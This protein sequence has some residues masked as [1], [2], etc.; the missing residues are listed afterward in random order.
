[1]LTRLIRHGSARI[2]RSARERLFRNLGWDVTTPAFVQCILTERCNYKCQY[3]SH[4]RMD[5]YSD[6]M[7]LEEWRTAITS[8]RKL[9]SPLVIDFTGG[10]PTIHPD[11]LEIA[12]H[13]R[14]QRV[15]W[16]M[17]TNGSTLSKIRFVER[18]V[19][20]KPLKIDVSVDSGS[21]TV[22]DNARGV[23]GSLA[24]IECGLRHLVSEQERTGHRFPIRIKVTVHRLNAHKLTPVVKWA[25]AFG[26]TSIDFNPVGGLWR[27]EQMENLSIREEDFDGLKREIQKLIH[28]KSEGA[29]IETSNEHLLG[30]ADHF[31]GATEFGTRPCRDPVRNFV[32]KP[33]GD[34]IACGCSPPIG[35]VRQQSAKQIWR[36]ESARSARVKSLSC[37]LKV[38][39]AKGASSCMAQKTIGDDF[40]RA[41]LI[42]GFGSKRAH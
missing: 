4:W 37:S 33:G 17:T 27:K 6:E 26:A 12:E 10:E 21:G 19:A 34:V 25:E 15:D 31:S 22:H 14:S 8:L 41:L 16:F 30:M 7:S 39:K 9:A 35:N 5:A 28:M 42:F 18:V 3:C 11:F 24:R 36:G 13:C 38:A 23:T 2:E 1:M 40:R 29:P 20:A 32:I